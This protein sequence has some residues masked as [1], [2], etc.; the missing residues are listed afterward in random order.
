MLTPDQ[1]SIPEPVQRAAYKRLPMTCD[2]V[3]EIL[4]EVKVR[5]M[6]EYDLDPADEAIIDAIVS[7]AFQQLRDQVTQPFRTEQMRLLHLIMKKGLHSDL[8]ENQI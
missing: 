3:R 7:Y 6:H 1:R 8:Q 2:K 5:T 4:D